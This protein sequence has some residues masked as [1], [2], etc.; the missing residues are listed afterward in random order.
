LSFFKNNNRRLSDD[1]IK[2]IRHIKRYTGIKGRKKNL[3]S[4][5]WAEF[6]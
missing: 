4:G 1:L 5:P 2:D 3:V 6:L